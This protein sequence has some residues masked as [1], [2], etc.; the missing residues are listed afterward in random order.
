[1]HLSWTML[2]QSSQL[3]SVLQDSCDSRWCVL[4]TSFSQVV[5]VK[6]LAGTKSATAPEICTIDSILV[7]GNSLRWGQDDNVG[8]EQLLATRAVERIWLVQ[9]SCPASLLIW[10]ISYW[11]C[12][13]VQCFHRADTDPAVASSGNNVL[14]ASIFVPV[15]AV[16][17]FHLLRCFFPSQPPLQ[18]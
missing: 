8:V 6:Q 7:E 5:L 17:C 3:I 4:C 10:K 18:W 14:I 9:A 2:W 16:E 15:G 13:W 11:C 12:S 1:M